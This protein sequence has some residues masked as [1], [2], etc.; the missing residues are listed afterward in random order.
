MGRIRSTFYNCANEHENDVIKQYATIPLL[1]IDDLLVYDESK[2]AFGRIGAILGKRKE[3]D[4][5][6][7]VTGYRSVMELAEIEMEITGQD[8]IASILS[9]FHR[10]ALSDRD[11]RA[12]AARG[13]ESLRPKNTQTGE[14]T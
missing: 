10:I 4:L 12:E 5:F 14:P 6:T 13:R 9:G 3:S 7:I 8:R 1:V 2:W 11:W